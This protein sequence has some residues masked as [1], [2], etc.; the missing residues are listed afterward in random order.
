MTSLAKCALATEQTDKEGGSRP[1]YAP[2]FL[3]TFAVAKKG[4]MLH[5]DKR[6]TCVLFVKH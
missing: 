4:L 1:P 2:Q 3:Q 6:W 5:Y